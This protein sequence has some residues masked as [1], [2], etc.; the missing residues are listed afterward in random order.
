VPDP[1]PPAEQL[2]LNLSETPKSASSKSA[3]TV[4]SFVDAGTL[5]VRREAIE[6]VKARGIF[7]APD[8]NKR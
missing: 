3:A 2:R 1:E 8:L 4:V 6:R 5:A 7:Q